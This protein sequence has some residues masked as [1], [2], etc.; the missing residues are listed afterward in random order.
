MWNDLLTA[1]ALVFILEGIM[2]FVNP[3]SLRKMIVLVAQ[4]DD[5][6]LRFIGLSSMIAGLV[7]LYLVH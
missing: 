1:L 3:A 6:S 5:A 2:P 7:L 4:M